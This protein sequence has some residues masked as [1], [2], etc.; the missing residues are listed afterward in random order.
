MEHALLIGSS[1][2][3]AT[4]A[5]NEESLFKKKYTSWNKILKVNT[6]LLSFL[7]F[8]FFEI[9]LVLLGCSFGS[10]KVLF[11]SLLFS[12]CQSISLIDFPFGI[13]LEDRTSD[14]FNI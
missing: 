1:N 6:R 8:F 14:T 9:F 11:I 10:V 12:N 13:Q 2:F 3:F 7:S 4:S 5:S